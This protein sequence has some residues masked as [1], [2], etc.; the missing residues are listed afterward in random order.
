MVF[1]AIANGLFREKFLTNHFNELKSHQLST[2]TM[3]VLLTV[4]VWILF[5]GWFPVSINQ[6]IMIG[7]LWFILTIIFEFLFGHYIAGH[8]WGKLLNDYNLFSGRIWILVLIWIAVLPYVIY[9]IQIK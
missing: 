7:L 3:I 5:K 6:V 1:I 8:S 2:V 4:Y 9:Q